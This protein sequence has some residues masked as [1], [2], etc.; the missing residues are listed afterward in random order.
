MPTIPSSPLVNHNVP[1]GFD[2]ADGVA[3]GS[4]FPAIGTPDP[5]GGK[6][7]FGKAALNE[8]PDSPEIERAEQATITHT[9]VLSSWDSAVT[10]LQVYGRGALLVDSSGNYS[11]V[12]SSRIKHGRGGK[13]ELTIVAE[14]ISFDNPPDEF[15]I[16]PVELGVDILKHP[17]YFYSLMPTS[18]IQGWEGAADTAVEE[19]VKQAIIRSL[20]TYRDA[21]FVPT[22]TNI[23]SFIGFNQDLV[24][25]GMSSGKLTYRIPNPDYDP[26][27]PAVPDVAVD[28][29]PATGQNCQFLVKSYDATTTASPSIALARAA[30]L[31]IIQKLWR[32]EDTPYTTGWQ[33][34]WAEYFFRPPPLNPGGYIENPASASPALPD[35]FLSTAYPP[36]NSA[37]IFD[38][39]A[40]K[41]PQCYSV[42]GSI[43]GT[44]NMSWLRKADEIEYQRTW[45][46][47][48]RTWIG[49]PL[50]AWDAD[51]YNQKARPKLPSDYRSYQLTS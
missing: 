22:K 45:F 1:S 41:N 49:A 5:A 44:A 46:K 28:T 35:Y 27:K 25:R 2:R 48:T 38:D 33:V 26:T 18:Q 34:T 36:N 21:Q 47:V 19:T 20:Q 30:A 29:S 13:V 17:R 15:N 40:K 4:T 42:D 23:D 14:S 7:T 51:L 10:L 31:E 39:L 24:V 9:A 50:G 43:G 32:M 37:T 3:R 11:R 6:L 12:L 16:V 8:S